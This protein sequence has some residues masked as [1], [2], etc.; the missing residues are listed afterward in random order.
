MQ[1]SVQTE[2]VQSFSA[3]HFEAFGLALRNSEERGRHV[4]VGSQKGAT[5]G[6]FLFRAQPYA[7]VLRP[8]FA[9][10][11]CRYCFA[12]LKKAKREERVACESPAVP[13]S[14]GCKYAFYCNRDCERTDWEMWHEMECEGL[15]NIY[16][17][18]MP[19]ENVMLMWRVVNRRRKE[20]QRHEGEVTWEVIDFM[21]THRQD[22]DPQEINHFEY[23][24]ERY[25]IPFLD[26]GTTKEHIVS[27]FCFFFC[28][29]FTIYDTT[30]NSIGL[31][32]YPSG[33]LMNHSCRPNTAVT[34]EG[35]VALIR[36]IEDVSPSGEITI[37]YM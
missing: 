15:R 35:N 36:A 4:C 23:L 17:P 11:H 21:I 28:N 5:K 19:N 37:N 26:E 34:F 22:Y 2:R 10:S 27:F 30:P 3:K 25:F 9:H 12:K 20:Q 7:A 1:S 31:G 24:V 29:N 6:S 13:C 18:T 14:K 8:A 33:A 16:P 32:V